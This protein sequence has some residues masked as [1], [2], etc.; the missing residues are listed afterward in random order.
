MTGVQTCALPI[1]VSTRSGAAL[2]QCSAGITGTLAVI[3]SVGSATQLGATNGFV[4]GEDRVTV[5]DG[6]GSTQ[7]VTVAS[8]TGGTDSLTIRRVDAAQAVLDVTGWFL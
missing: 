4:E 8:G 2:P 3:P 6:T 5:D 7:R 1:S